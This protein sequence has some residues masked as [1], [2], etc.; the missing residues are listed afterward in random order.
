MCPCMFYRGYM[1]ITEVKE[2]SKTKYE[3]ITE[4][5]QRMVLYKGDMRRYGLHEGG[6]I[7]EEQISVLLH[8]IL[9]KRARERCMKL[10]QGRDYAESE[11]RK[12]LISDGYPEQVIADAIT[13][14]QKYDYI[15]D[16]RYIR[17]YYQ[18][19]SVRKSKKQIILDL[20]QKGIEKQLI[21]DALKDIVMEEGENRDLDCIRRLLF[22][23]RYEDDEATYE[24]KEKMKM[25]L[26]RKGFELSDIVMGMKNFS[27][28]EMEINMT[29]V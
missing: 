28:R 7:N 27:F 18:S 2:Y 21:Q 9:P 25:Y 11:I 12:K 8:E 14:L 6:E 4:D 19:K 15:N 24:I 3:I 1:K 22:K 13:F 20:Q 17:L 16:L 23:K 26:Y 29:G 10:L 5:E